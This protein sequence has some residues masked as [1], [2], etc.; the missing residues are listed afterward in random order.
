[1]LQRFQDANTTLYIY[2]QLSAGN[3]IE[4]SM[5]AYKR[6]FLKTSGTCFVFDLSINILR[7]IGGY[8]SLAY[9]GNS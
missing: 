8:G 6:L 2:N 1:M 3:T 9:S 5:S 7:L 4:L